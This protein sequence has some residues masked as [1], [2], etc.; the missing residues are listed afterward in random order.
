MRSEER[1]EEGERIVLLR[2][3]HHPRQAQR[4][5]ASTRS[6]QMSHVNGWRAATGRQ[7]RT[8]N[9]TSASTA[10]RRG[11]INVR[12][13]RTTPRTASVHRQERVRSI[14]EEMSGFC[15]LAARPSPPWPLLLVRAAFPP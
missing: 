7:T 15:A 10:E 5:T 14:D 9:A 11:G 1:G 3:L 4:T 2:P 6:R 12:T 8:S 13:R